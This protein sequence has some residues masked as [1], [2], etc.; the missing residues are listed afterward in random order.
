[1]PQF[2]LFPFISLFLRS[3]GEWREARGEYE[4]GGRRVEGSTRRVRERREASGGKHE[5]SARK[6]RGEWREARGE[7]EKGARGKTHTSGC[8]YSRAF[9]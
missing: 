8:L 9:L 2:L 6:A 3:S 5:A 4:K 1:M 7:C